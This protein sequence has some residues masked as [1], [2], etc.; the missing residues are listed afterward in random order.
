VVV[1]WSSGESGSCPEWL[2]DVEHSNDTIVVE[3]ERSGGMCTDDY[4]PYRVVLAVHRERLPSADELP[5]A[6]LD[7]VPD[8]EARIYPLGEG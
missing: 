8:G 2:A 4:N 1:V 5:S 7:G 3:R 6:Q